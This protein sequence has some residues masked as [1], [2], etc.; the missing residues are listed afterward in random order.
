MHIHL[1]PVG[2][3]AGDMFVAAMLDAF[4][5]LEGAVQGAAR[6]AG[7]PERFRCELCPHQDHALSGKRFFVD[8]TIPARSGALVEG[9]ILEPG[10]DHEHGHRH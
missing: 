9:A 5:A 8:E 3:I 6:A 7:L 10:R 2:G 1:D 4:P